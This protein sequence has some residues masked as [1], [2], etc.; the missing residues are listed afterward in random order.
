MVELA[1]LYPGAWTSSWIGLQ[2]TTS[3]VIFDTSK[4]R[5]QHSHPVFRSQI[6]NQI[7]PLAVF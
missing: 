3:G 2:T 1:Q 6:S 4:V 7:L 5:D